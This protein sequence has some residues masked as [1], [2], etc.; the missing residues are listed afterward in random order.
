MLA[1]KLP[2]E[3]ADLPAPRRSGPY[4]PRRLTSTPTNPTEVSPIIGHTYHLLSQSNGTDA[5]VDAV[6]LGGHLVAVA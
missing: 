3:F 2:Q 6:T 1:P 5:E 4:P